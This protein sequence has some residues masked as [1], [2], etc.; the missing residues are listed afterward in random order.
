M[1]PVVRLVEDKDV[2]MIEGSISSET[3]YES[4]KVF[5]HDQG[6]FSEDELIVEPESGSPNAITSS[7]VNEDGAF[8]LAFVDSGNYLTLSLPC[9]MRTMNLWKL[10]PLLKI[11]Q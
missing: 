11:F 3:E 8:M 4:L 6:T 7:D 2:A 1:K 9:L 5:A 10:W